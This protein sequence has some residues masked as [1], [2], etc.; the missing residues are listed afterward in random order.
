MSFSFRSRLIVTTVAVVACALLSRPVVVS[1]GP[2]CDDAGGTCFTYGQ[3]QQLITQT[4]GVVDAGQLDCGAQMAC[5][6]SPKAPP[7]VATCSSVTGYCAI[8]CFSDED[9]GA[10]D[11]PTK[12]DEPLSRCCKTKTSVTPAPAGNSGILP[13]S[14]APSGQAPQG[15][16]PGSVKN[17]IDTGDC[18]L[19]DIVMTGVGFA[20]FLLGL[21]GALFL[22]IFIYG[23]AMYLLSF[24]NKSMVERG[25]K[26]IKGAA[27]GMIIVLSAWTIVSQIVKGITGLSGGAN[28]TQTAG[29]DANCKAQGAGYTCHTFEGATAN[30]VQQAWATQGFECK[31]G[32]CPGDF[33]TV[34]CKV[35]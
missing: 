27:F 22:V 26:A 16:I 28:A 18:T 32:Y 6:V 4:P 8:D 11:C 3:C 14:T 19:D 31:T 34:C 9:K 33:H 30:N 24:G 29:S 35:K 17:C 1:A 12:T 20:N 25:T 13:G 15:I 5:C 21:S 7:P 2:L 10:L 23:G